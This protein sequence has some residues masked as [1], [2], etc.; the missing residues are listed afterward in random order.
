MFPITTTT[1]GTHE[2]FD[3]CSSKV[4]DIFAPAGFSLVASVLS[5][6]LA[7]SG[8]SG[9]SSSVSGSSAAAGFIALG[10]V[11]VASGSIVKRSLSV[12]C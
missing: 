2:L 9:D 8:S 7:A 1:E 4:W 10:W 3:T 12:P 6:V 5:A 11:L